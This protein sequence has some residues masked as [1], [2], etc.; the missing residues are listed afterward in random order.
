MRFK[1]K[2]NLLQQPLKAHTAPIEEFI[3]QD[4]YSLSLRILKNKHERR[5]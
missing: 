2:T 1:A 3:E 5:I 4:D